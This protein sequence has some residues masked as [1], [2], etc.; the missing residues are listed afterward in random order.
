M[1]AEFLRFEL[2][3]RL[4][5]PTVYIF[6]LVFGLL[7]FGAV[8]SDAVV[9]G[10][11]V[12]QVARNAPYVIAAFMLTM[13]T[14][15]VLAT[16]AF[17][18]TAVTRDFDLHTYSLF[19]SKPIRKVDYLGGRFLGSL[20]VSML[21]MVG[22]AL[23]L[24]VGSW[25]P[26][27]E[28]ERLVAFQL[29]PYLHAL[30]ALALPNLLLMGALVFGV[31]AVTRRVLWSYVAVVGFFVLYG[32]SQ[33]LLSDLDSETLGAI[34]DPF[35]GAAM[36]LQTRYWTVVERNSQIVRLEG[37]LLLN[38]LL[39]SGL[40]I[41]AVAGVVLRFRLQTPAVR[42]AAILDAQPAFDEV[43][44]PRASRRFDRGAHVAQWW[45]QTRVEVRGV[46]RGGPYIALA[47]FA[48]AMTVANSFAFVDQLF[49]TSVYPTTSV[50]TDMVV[51]GF[52]LFLMIVVT[53]YAGELVW[54]ERRVALH[55]V[56][57]ALP[58]PSWVPL[59]A[60]L[61]ALVVGVAV[62]LAVGM[63]TGIAIQLARGYTHLELLLYVQ[64]LFG[65]ALST[66]ALTAVLALF[67][68]VLA[69]HKYLG[70]LL[71]ILFYVADVVLPQLD[72]DHGLY[73]FATPRQMPWSD[74]NG[75]GHFV[76]RF[77]WFHVYWALVAVFLMLVANL[78]WV[79]GTDNRLRL[80]ARAARARVTRWNTAVLAVTA[81][82]VLSTG[83]FIY[84][85]T[86]V[87]ND[88]RNP[89]AE[90]E[91]R[92]EYER[93]YKQYEDLPQPRIVAVD[94]A[95]DLQPDERRMRVE[96][97]LKLKNATDSPIDTL[98]LQIDA[99]L[100]WELE[101]PGAALD[102]DD[103]EL[104]YR[105]YG[106][107]PALAA[108]A[109]ITVH[110]VSR[111]E[112]PGFV[113]G[114]SNT[115]VV[116]NGTFVN[117]IRYTPH[118]GYARDAELSDPNERRK[119][120]LPE[121][122][123]ALKIDDPAGHRIN[124]LSHE[125]DWIEFSATVSTAPDQ[126]A[127]APGYLQREWTEN[128]RRFFRYEMDAPILNFWSVLSARYEVARS[129]WNDVAIE[130]YHHPSHGV[131]VPRMIEAIGK[132]LD[133]FTESFGPY[134]YRQVRIIEFPRYQRFAQ[135]FPNTIP[136]SESI[137]FVADLRDPEDIDYVF[138]VTAHEVAHQWWG[139]QVTPAAVQ[140][141][142]MLVETMAQ[143]SALMVMEKEY[144][145]AHMHRFLRYELDRYLAGRG[146]ERHEEL[147][148][149]LVENQQYIH[150]NKGSLVLYALRDYVGEEVLN[151]A[152]AKFV[153]EWKFRGPPYPTTRDFIEA[154]APVV[155][156]RYAYLVEDLFETI[157]LY[158]NRAL[159][160]TAEPT[161]DGRFRVKL[162]VLSRKLRADGKG[163]ETEVDMDDVLE[164]G[165]YAA[166]EEGGDP[167]ALYSEK[168]ELRAGESEI[169][170][171]VDERPHEAGIDPDVL[172]V[173][174]DPDDNRRKIDVAGG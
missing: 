156:P 30:F 121:R 13:S 147:P 168:H 161:E 120:G 162:K 99:D 123:R 25:M 150:Y 62:L 166:P 1:F 135:S 24:V 148:L 3:Y 39:W 31:A 46:L 23:G 4:R 58:V 84:Y 49:G 40:A 67:F 21:V 72:L 33:S 75:F 141:A 143:Y 82:A 126:I 88:Y 128:G 111:F 137:G 157:T 70:F 171:I 48:I 10:G 16:T 155:P 32:V 37:P 12:G 59:L 6:A 86:N 165:I 45:F 97:D 15:A 167:R 76:D 163:G 100:Q 116:E 43:E 140:G 93:R 61:A 38:R 142:T 60:K 52:Y 153:A 56:Y 151:R 29:L 110:F 122:A 89:D 74:M 138:Y 95:I 83:G 71:M 20:V 81:A 90:T 114:G 170:V 160:A 8:T 146:T 103:A 115:D 18:A 108:G 112:E 101:V 9:I 85:N 51:S 94:V 109:E 118:V 169:E 102:H 66:F 26:W 117:N 64:Q 22:A 105:I 36:D 7:T 2:K 5:Q 28:P 57:D 149:A 98:H 55:E 164:I 80:R 119:R 19:F 77:V 79:R 92:V 44:I 14:V 125:A 73:R 106:L 154:I 96:G 139:H 91:L 132:S 134:Q 107:Q 53:Y 158:D 78:F 152:I 130:V 87:L 124:M 68:Q 35:G 136:Y 133:Y 42:T 47:L 69:N 113:N 173:D 131:N 172:F 129:S 54:K 159:A 63:I 145:P 41:V 144:G 65:V 127:I 11:S 27:I 50:V 17:F 104:G 34:F 174:R